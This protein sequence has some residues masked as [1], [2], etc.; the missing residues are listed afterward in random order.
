MFCC[1]IYCTIFPETPYNFVDKYFMGSCTTFI[2]KVVQHCTHCTTQFTMFCVVF[3][4]MFQV[5]F[6]LMLYN[7]FQL[8]CTMF[9]Q[10]CT[11]LYI[12]TI[13]DKSWFDIFVRLYN[14]MIMF[15]KRCTRFCQRF[16]C[17]VQFCCIFVRYANNSS[18]SSPFWV[19]RSRKISAR[20][21]SFGNRR[22]LWGAWR[23]S[24]PSSRTGLKR[25]WFTV[26]ASKSFSVELRRAKIIGTQDIKQCILFTLSR[27]L[28]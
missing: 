12:Q 19:R 11:T 8:N 18:Y 10:A 17:I 28:Q 27:L 3:C 14:L 24:S 13:I 16:C 21:P 5:I 25:S 20:R 7:I 23:Q 2:L 15:L 1:T 4:K 6:T 22:L 26:L 9:I